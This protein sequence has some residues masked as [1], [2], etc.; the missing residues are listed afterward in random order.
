MGLHPK[1][2][3]FITRVFRK[4]DQNGDGNL[5]LQEFRGAYNAGGHPDV[6]K[7]LKTQEEVLYDFFKCFDSDTNPDGVISKQEF[8][9]HY[10]GISAGIASDDQFIALLSSTWN[11]GVGHDESSHWA[12]LTNSSD[13]S[14]NSFPSISGKRLPFVGLDVTLNTVNVC[15]C[16]FLY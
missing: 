4:F 5:D 6:L 13:N 2:K 16:W 9:Q 1:R 11:L 15:C 3:A 8:E 12:A 14:N 10:S 7:G